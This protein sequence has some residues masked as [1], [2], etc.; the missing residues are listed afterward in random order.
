MVR[1][2]DKAKN[3]DTML[4]ALGAALGVILILLPASH[5]AVIVALLAILFGLLV[6]PTLQLPVARKS[7][8]RKAV[9]I[10]GLVA[11]VCAF[12]LFVWPQRRYLDLT[13]A[14]QQRFVGALR[15][16]HPSKRVVVGCG[17]NEDICTS[18][19]QFIELFHKANWTVR[20][21]TMER[22]FL[23][24]PRFGV[25]IL[26][27]GTGII[28]DPDNPKYGLWAM[29]VNPERSAVIQAF[30][31]IGITITKTMVD[32]QLGEHEIAIIF[33]PEPPKS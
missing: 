3:H 23:A 30:K 1:P 26:I 32:R 6:H 28:P 4:A 15:Q 31:S 22:G 21:N 16:V 33:G 24:T 13:D 10:C 5:P 12:G 9:G 7:A 25:T 29:A 8:L 27:Y 14:E 2:K 18:A 19:A 17:A 11:A 20:G